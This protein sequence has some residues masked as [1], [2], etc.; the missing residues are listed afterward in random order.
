MQD[1]N[2]PTFT[3]KEIKNNGLRGLSIGVPMGRVTL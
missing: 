2:L 1:K 3:K